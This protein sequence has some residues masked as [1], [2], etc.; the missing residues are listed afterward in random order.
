M[1]AVSPGRG[2]PLPPTL[3]GWQVVDPG[4][5]PISSLIDAVP[6]TPDPQAQLDWRTRVEADN[7]ALARR[8]G[9]Q[10]LWFPVPRP[11]DEPFIPFFGGRP[12]AWQSAVTTL[13]AALVRG[14][15]ARVSV[16]N[17]TRTN[18]LA[19]LH[20]ASARPSTKWRTEAD[21]LSPRGSTIDV[22]AFDDIDELATV[23]ADTVRMSG[24]TGAG[25]DAGSAKQALLKVG[26]ALG[27]PVPITR[28]EHALQMVLTNATPRGAS[29]T[30]SEETELRRLHGEITQ[31]RSLQDDLDRLERNLGSLSSFAKD[32]GKR[33]RSMGHGQVRVK[34]IEIDSQ[35]SMHELFL[36]QQVVGQFLS[37][38]FG[39]PAPSVGPTA[40]LVI[41]AD[42]IPDH[43]LDSLISSAHRFGKMLVLLFE[44]LDDRTKR[45]LGASGSKTAVFFALPNADE[46]ENAAKYLGR[47]YKFVVN[48]HSFSE[49][50]SEQ[51]S[52]T[53][54]VSTD[55]STSRSLN[56]GREFGRSLTRGFSEGSSTADLRGGGTGRERGQTR[57]RVHEYVI[58]PEEF[59][60]LPDTA[61]L[62]INDKNVTLADCDPSIRGRPS[63]STVPYRPRF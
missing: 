55:A 16:V 1:P 56:F 35:G 41:G 20:R 8:H 53:H 45:Y 25:F 46:A 24:D 48:G 30:K 3:L 15:Y 38:Y 7:A 28:L 12:A 61:I 43:L 29:F 21:V 63:T 11:R 40:L 47:A 23:I 26:R 57:G 59:Q 51:W 2:R 9:Q 13:T 52:T 5:P 31:R 14:G 18:A 60:K 58:E 44:H 32:P 22:M 50:T 33:S 37:R 34:T 10:P 17:L 27:A 6:N 54:S 42:A 62:V 4:A 49:S 36:A 39:R 19:T